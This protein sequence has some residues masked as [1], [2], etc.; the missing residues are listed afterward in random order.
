MKKTTV[1]SR[2]QMH[3]PRN[4]VLHGLFM[5]LYGCVKYLAFPLCDYLRFAAVR[6][7]AP[8][9][10]TTY[11]CEA[12]TFWFPWRIHLGKKSSLNHGVIVDGTGG[13]FIGEGVRIGFYTIISTADHEFNSRQERII[14]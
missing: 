7:F 1:M 9:V 2:S 12:V 8:Y 4:Y 11:I 13:V 5:V 3:S 14:D 6:L 10:R